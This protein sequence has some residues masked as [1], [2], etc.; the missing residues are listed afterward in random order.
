MMTSIAKRLSA[1]DVKN[2][3]SYIEGLR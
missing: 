2:L 1:D 3:A